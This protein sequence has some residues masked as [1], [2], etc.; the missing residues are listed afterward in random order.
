MCG[1]LRRDSITA[2]MGALIVRNVFMCFAKFLGAAISAQAALITDHAL[3][4]DSGGNVLN[5]LL[6]PD[7]TVD[8]LV[9]SNS[10]IAMAGSYKA[11]AS[12]RGNT[13]VGV[14]A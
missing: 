10:K 14:R 12:A 1:T 13:L 3:L 11:T 7:V 2:L 8:G 5:T 9:G 4:P 6:G